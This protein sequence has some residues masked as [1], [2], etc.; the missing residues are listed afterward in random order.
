MDACERCQDSKIARNVFESMIQFHNQ[1]LQAYCHFKM[2][3]RE[4]Y[5]LC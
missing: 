1:Y 3:D 2:Y 5:L 4:G